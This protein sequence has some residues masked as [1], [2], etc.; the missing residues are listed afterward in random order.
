VAKRAPK[1][2]EKWTEQQA[3]DAG[4]RAE[5]RGIRGPNNPQMQWQSKRHL[6][7]LETAYR[8]L[9]PHDNVSADEFN[10]A[11]ARRLMRPVMEA[12]ETC[13]MHE[14]PIP[15]WA[16]QPFRAAMADL[17]FSERTVIVNSKEVQVPIRTWGDAFGPPPYLLPGMHPRRDG[18][19]AR[20]ARGNRDFAVAM[21]V[22]RSPLP[23]GR[24]QG[25]AFA[26][27]AKAHGLTAKTV[28]AIWHARSE[29]FPEQRTPQKRGRKPKRKGPST[30]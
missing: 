15:Q 8:K 14:W 23:L 30:K 6:R 10:A 18:A 22:A 19:R 17:R 5:K 16:A 20:L 3:W 24:Q 11:L 12:I 9:L 21:D 13:A 7:A 4:L 1:V 28:E 26:E 27:V 29:W 25:C 2:N